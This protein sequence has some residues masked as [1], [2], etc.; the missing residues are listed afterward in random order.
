VPRSVRLGNEAPPGI[1]DRQHD[2]CGHEADDGEDDQQLDER[3]TALPIPP[4]SGCVRFTS[5]RCR[6]RHCPP[7]RPRGRQRPGNRCRTAARRGPGRVAIGVA[8]GIVRQALDEPFRHQGLESL[9][10]GRV[11]HAVEAVHLHPLLQRRDIGFGLADPRG[12]LGGQDVDDDD[13]RQQADDDDHHHQLDEGEALLALLPLPLVTPA[14]AGVC[15][16]YSR[17]PVAE[18]PAFAGM[19]CKYLHAPVANVSS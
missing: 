13:R 5:S 3:E 12:I 19:T 7:R 9:S 2:G 18:I 4:G 1:R 16:E 11:V 10:S 17:D 8:P 6:Y 14:K 15:A